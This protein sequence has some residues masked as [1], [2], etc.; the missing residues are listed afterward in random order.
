[1]LSRFSH[2][3]VFATPWTVAHEGPLSMGFFKQE[4]WSGFSCPP[5]GHPPNAGFKPVSL[6]ALHWQERLGGYLY[7]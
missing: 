5:P 4:Y 7:R 6:T 3:W 2:V 1:M